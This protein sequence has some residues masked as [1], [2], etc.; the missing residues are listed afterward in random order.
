M[1]KIAPPDEILPYPASPRFDATQNQDSVEHKM[2]TSPQ[3]SHRESSDDEML[4]SPRL[5]IERHDAETVE[6]L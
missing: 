3:L 6:R 4:P 5:D 2:L 1:Q